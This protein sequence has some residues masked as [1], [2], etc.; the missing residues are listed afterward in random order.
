MSW[1]QRSE[2]PSL[3]NTEL[4]DRPCWRS[5]IISCVVA[6]SPEIQGGPSLIV[7]DQETRVG[8]HNNE[9]ASERQSGCEY[10]LLEACWAHILA[11]LRDPG[12]FT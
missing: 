10:V 6:Q 1:N 11:L 9:T 3:G 2:E 8:L 12:Q 4:R 5:Q 7:L